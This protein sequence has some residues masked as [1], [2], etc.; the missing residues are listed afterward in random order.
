MCTRPRT[1]GGYR[2]GE[3][4]FGHDYM[5]DE[6]VA[7]MYQAPSHS[8]DVSPSALRQCSSKLLRE[9]NPCLAIIMRSSPKP[10]GDFSICRAIL[11]DS[12]SRR[13]CCFLRADV[14]FLFPARKKS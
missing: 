4:R 10:L 8:Q 11:G 6:R 7:N 2:T 14:V 5:V 3:N 12:T 9:S 13:S 1:R